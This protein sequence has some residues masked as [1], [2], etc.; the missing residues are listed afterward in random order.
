[1]FGCGGAL[2]GSIGVRFRSSNQAL[3]VQVLPLWP[4][5]APARR[6]VRSW[7]VNLS[8]RYVQ[9]FVPVN[10]LLRSGLSRSERFAPSLPPAWTILTSSVFTHPESKSSV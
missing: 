9:S 3:P 6:V 4:R 2:G 7:E 5:R 10:E 1:M 8:V